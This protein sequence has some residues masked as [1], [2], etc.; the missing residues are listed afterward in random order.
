[1]DIDLLIND[2]FP[3]RI[4][5]LYNIPIKDISYKEIRSKCWY[6]LTINGAPFLA[7]ISKGDES[8]K[9]YIR[10]EVEFINFLGQHNMPVCRVLASKE[11]RLFEVMRI[12]NENHDLVV[13]EESVGKDVEIQDWNPNLFCK[14]GTL[15][16]SMHRIANSFSFSSGLATRP[17]WNT[18]LD[19]TMKTQI[20]STEFDMFEKLV[21]IMDR[22]K[23]WPTDNNTYGLIHADFHSRNFKLENGDVRLFDFDRCEYN[24]FV[25][26][27]A[28][29]I[30]FSMRYPQNLECWRINKSVQTYDDIQ[31]KVSIFV[32][33]LLAGYREIMPLEK[34]WLNRIPQILKFRDI[35]MYFDFGR[36]QWALP[37]I[38]SDYQEYLN[39]TKTRIMNDSPLIE[40]DLSMY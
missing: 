16:G 26:D 40:L 38:P 8:T 24:W 37:A 2:I 13:F 31:E 9:I 17:H 19:D 27:I 33:N 32:E 21:Q 11:N 14:M 39:D 12:D 22:M 1:M 6:N 29:A 10:G 15:L 34:A 4:S 25:Y 18:G 35:L 5:K 20:P 36:D 23:S 30:Y 7:R 28:N 3:N